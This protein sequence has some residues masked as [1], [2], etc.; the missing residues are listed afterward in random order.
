MVI[1]DKQLI[2]PIRSRVIH[3]MKRLLLLTP[4]LLLG[5]GCSQLGNNWMGFYYPNMHD[6]TKYEV[7]DTFATLD[8]CHDW[9][10]RQQAKFD[11]EGVNLDD[12]ECGTNCEYKEEMDVYLCDETE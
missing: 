12:S 7:S 4:L 3:S 6:L 11:P 9:I 8:E 1:I 2:I 5:A 10:G